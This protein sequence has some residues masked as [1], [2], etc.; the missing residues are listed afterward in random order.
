MGVLIDV[1]LVSFSGAL[2]YP[3]ALKINLQSATTLPACAA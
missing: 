2:C 3:M 1:S